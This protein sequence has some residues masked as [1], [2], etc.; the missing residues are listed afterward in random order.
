MANHNE[1][2]LE[3]MTDSNEWPFSIF[4][5][6][7]IE[8]LFFTI[9]RRHIQLIYWYIFPSIVFRFQ[10]SY[11]HTLT[12]AQTHIH[13]RHGQYLSMTYTKQTDW[14]FFFRIFFLFTNRQVSLIFN[15]VCEMWNEADRHSSH[16]R[17]TQRTIA[18]NMKRLMQKQ[19][20]L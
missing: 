19:K 18:T 12:H 14:P 1:T 10:Y 11:S 15:V 17:T 6:F 13:I 16:K 4:V 2:I 7:M 3:R 5:F 20:N 9:P 8:Y